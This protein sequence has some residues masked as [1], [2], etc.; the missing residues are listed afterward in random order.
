MLAGDVTVEVVD[1]AGFSILEITGDENSNRIELISDGTTV[2]VI[3]KGTDLNGQ[4][5][6]LQFSVADLDG[7]I[8]ALGDGNDQVTMIADNDTGTGFIGLGMAIDMGAGNDRVRL[9]AQNDNSSQNGFHF[10]IVQIE[11]SDGNDRVEMF[12]ENTVGVGF[13]N[14][15]EYII[16]TGSGN[17]RVTLTAETQAVPSSNA[18]AFLIDDFMTINTHDSDGGNDRVSITTQNDGDFFV[19]ENLNIEVGNGR[20]RIDIV[21]SDAGEI[22]VDDVLNILAGDGGNRINM[23][24]E[25]SSGNGFDIGNEILVETGA[26]SDRIAIRA[27]NSSSNNGFTMA[28]GLGVLSGAGNDRID[29]VADNDAGTGFYMESGMLLLGDEGDDRINLVARGN[30]QNGFVVNGFFDFFGSRFAYGVEGG[31]GNDRITVDADNRDGT[32]F[33]SAETDGAMLIGGGNHDDRVTLDSRL[34]TGF[35]I[36]VIEVDGGDGVDR[37][38]NDAVLTAI[39]TNF[40]Q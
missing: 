23:V 1:Q 18:M 3:G 15:A 9:I 16:N 40:E 28:G 14:E 2:S 19:G 8:V 29:V 21:A 7:Y 12:A 38:N 31:D 39:E 4:N 5:E 11:T 27:E 17:D 36:E 30:G 32:G 22:K 20:N 26:G 34:A 33:F 25:N 13:R 10:G 35:D 24:A 37:L 6:T